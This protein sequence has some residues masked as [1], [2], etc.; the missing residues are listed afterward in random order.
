MLKS[1][2][3]SQEEE[4][5]KT[6]EDMLAFL[7]IDCT[8]HPFKSSCLVQLKC[9]YRSAATSGCSLFPYTCLKNFSFP[10]LREAR[11]LC[12]FLNGHRE[13]HLPLCRLY[14]F[15]CLGFYLDEQPTVNL[16]CG[17]GGCF[18]G[19]VY[20]LSSELVCL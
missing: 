15:F 20:K 4:E 9:S 5:G 10:V 16:P 13:N 6:I 14:P 12:C 2:R 11:R 3:G 19:L 17:A 8:K 18:R 1:T 7:G